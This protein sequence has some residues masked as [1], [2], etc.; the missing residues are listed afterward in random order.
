MGAIGVELN[1]KIKDRFRAKAVEKAV[2]ARNAARAAKK[3][4]LEENPIGAALRVA[5]PWIAKKAGQAFSKGTKV[6]KGTG[7]GLGKGAGKGKA[8]RGRMS[9]AGAIGAGIGAAAGGGSGSG[10]NAPNTSS[11]VNHKFSLKPTTSSSVKD[12]SIKSTR[13]ERERQANLKMALRTES[14][15]LNTI[16]SIVENDISEQTV[17]FNENQITINNTVAKKLLNV[18]ESVNK[19]NKKKMEQMLNE[20]ATSFNKVLT[21]AVR[22]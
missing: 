12:T 9:L 18:Y 7:K 5:G 22:Q 8:S 6:T 2:T 11:A 4:T 10:S 17:R 20:S 13:D 14:N 21:F 19:T 3:T 15:V 1:K 16:K